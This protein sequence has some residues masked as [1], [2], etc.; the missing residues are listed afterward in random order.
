MFRAGS[1][2]VRELWKM[3]KES[4]QWKLHNRSDESQSWRDLDE[5][6]R[7]KQTNAQVIHIVVIR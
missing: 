5:V 4:Q 2:R 1:E 6:V 7:V 3:R